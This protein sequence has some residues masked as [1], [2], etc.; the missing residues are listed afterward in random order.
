MLKP[1]LFSRN[2]AMKRF[3]RLFVIDWHVAAQES[4]AG[5]VALAGR[6]NYFSSGSLTVSATLKV[7]FY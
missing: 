1:G 6:D 3:L 4:R 7:S 5:M 2:M